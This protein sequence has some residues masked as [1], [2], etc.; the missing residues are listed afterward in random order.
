MIWCKILAIVLSWLSVCRAPLHLFWLVALTGNKCQS[1]PIY[2]GCR[3]KERDG[4]KASC[5]QFLSCTLVVMTNPRRRCKVRPAPSYLT[6]SETFIL[7]SLSWHWSRDPKPSAPEMLRDPDPLPAHHSLI[8]R[9]YPSVS[10]QQPKSWPEITLARSGLNILK[11]P[12][13]LSLCIFYFSNFYIDIKGVLVKSPP[14]S[15]LVNY[16][17]F[18]PSFSVQA[19]PCFLK[20][21]ESFYC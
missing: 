16:S 21:A 9:Y 6:S 13:I 20:T 10:L 2:D 11:S 19:P 8:V 18:L 1:S 7:S 12:I 14:H 17:L 5:S 3:R 4:R 15:L